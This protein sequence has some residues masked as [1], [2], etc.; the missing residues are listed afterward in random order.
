MEQVAGKQGAG[1]A[2][3][4]RF[5]PARAEGGKGAAAFDDAVMGGAVELAQDN[6]A[7]PGGGER[8]GI[9]ADGVDVGAREDQGRGV[10]VGG[11]GLGGGRGGRRI[12]GG[13]RGDLALRGGDDRGARA[14][15]MT[16]EGEPVGVHADRAVT[17]SDTSA[18]VQRGEQIGGQAQM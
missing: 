9:G 2:G 15:G 14:H 11:Q 1:G 17:E 6:G 13:D 7:G 3:G 10:D 12:E 4:F 18:D 16:G 8:N 5:V